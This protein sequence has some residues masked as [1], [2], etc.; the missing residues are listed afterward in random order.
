MDDLIRRQDA[1]DVA[2]AIWATTGDKNVAKV[3]DMIKNLP[4]A[5]PE[6]YPVNKMDVI[7]ALANIK[8]IDYS[9]EVWKLIIKAISDI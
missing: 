5:Q 2:D 9:A 3:W 6:V 4:S 8:E 1:I 7:K